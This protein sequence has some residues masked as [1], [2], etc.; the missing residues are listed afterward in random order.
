MAAFFLVVGA[1][2]VLAAAVAV[3]TD[4]GRWSVPRLVVALLYAA[5]ALWFF[6]RARR[7]DADA[8]GAPRG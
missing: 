2:L 3:A 7:R 6:L 4:G 8:G 5:Y 1:V